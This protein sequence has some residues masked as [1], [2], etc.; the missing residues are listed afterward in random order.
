MMKLEDL[1]LS[2]CVKCNG[3]KAS[4]VK[5][6]SDEHAPGVMINRVTKHAENGSPIECEI[7]VV[8]PDDISEWICDER[9]KSEGSGPCDFGTRTK[10]YMDMTCNICRSTRAMLAY[11]D[12]Y[13]AEAKRRGELNLDTKKQF[14]RQRKLFLNRLG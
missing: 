9:F 1:K 5:I 6:I 8:K 12:K 2:Q 7:S 4:V 11:V 13:E 10:T 14:D 3:D